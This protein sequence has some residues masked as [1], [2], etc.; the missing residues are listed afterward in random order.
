MN[1]RMTSWALFFNLGGMSPFTCS[2]TGERAEGKGQK[3]GRS[4][5]E[6]P[7][8]GHSTLESWAETPETGHS[9]LESVP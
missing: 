3:G 8:T 7:E 5:A 6:T 4:W 2:I 9:T 1:S